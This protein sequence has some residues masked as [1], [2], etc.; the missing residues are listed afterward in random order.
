MTPVSPFQQTNLSCSR[1]DKPPQS[2]GGPCRNKLGLHEGP[3]KPLNISSTPLS[4]FQV[5][6]SP[7]TN[8]AFALLLDFRAAEYAYEQATLKQSQ[9]PDVSGK[10]DAAKKNALAFD[11][12]ALRKGDERMKIYQSN[13]ASSMLLLTCKFQALRY[14]SVSGR[15][16]TAASRGAVLPPQPDLNLCGLMLLYPVG[17]HYRWHRGY[18]TR[19][20]YHGARW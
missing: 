17:R 12:L 3:N 2:A 11:S 14:L 7:Q 6:S 8:T 16:A 5:Q 9:V 15:S 20:P 4:D 19:P 13:F 18:W 10:S 1:A